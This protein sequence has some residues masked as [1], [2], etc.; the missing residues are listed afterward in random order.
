MTN[1]SARAIAQEASVGARKPTPVAAILTTRRG[2]PAPGAVARTIATIRL[3]AR[4]ARVNVIPTARA[5][6]TRV[7]R[8]RSRPGALRTACAASARAVVARSGNAVSAAG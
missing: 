8:G 6:P 3:T 2:G 5:T 4:K 7:A 1:G